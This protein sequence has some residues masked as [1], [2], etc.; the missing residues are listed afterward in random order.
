MGHQFVSEGQHPGN[1]L[2]SKASQAPG[3][4][5]SATHRPAVTLEQFNPRLRHKGVFSAG[6][7]RPKIS[8]VTIVPDMIN[9]TCIAPWTG[10]AYDAGMSRRR[11]RICLITGVLL[12]LYSVGYLGVRLNHTLV[13]QIAANAAG[14]YLWHGVDSY[15]FDKPR[16]AAFYTPL[17]YVELGFWHLV[18]PLGSQLTDAEKRSFG[19]LPDT[20]S[21]SAN[22]KK[23]EWSSAVELIKSGQV[24][25]VIQSHSLDVGLQTTNG[26]W[27]ETQ[28][29]GIDQ[30]FVVIRQYA[31]NEIRQWTE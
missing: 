30:V 27:Y 20:N 14:N 28:E 21:P 24:T 12:A 11:T 7:E 3:S 16:L 23:I 29:P 8:C 19:L 4:A 13:H 1:A 15:Y 22:P 31:S 5:E 26:M 18:H 25:C 9:H 6:S 17:R 2:G 10:Q